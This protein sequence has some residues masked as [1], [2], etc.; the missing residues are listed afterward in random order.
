MDRISFDIYEPDGKKFHFISNPNFIVF[1]L[2]AIVIFFF[3]KFSEISPPYSESRE[4]I[5]GIVLLINIYYLLT[6]FFKYK[7]LNGEMNGEIIFEADSVIIN[8]KIFP[9]KSINNL[10]FWLGDYYGKKVIYGQSFSPSLYQGVNNYVQFTDNL[11][12]TQTIYFRMMTEHSYLSLCPFINEAV[13]LNKMQFKQA[14]DLV[15]YG[16]VSAN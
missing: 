1:S 4:I 2:W 8:K 6:S 3:W 13:K 12:Q 16:N 10:N 5:L 9:I 7:P 15:G 11:N 14:V